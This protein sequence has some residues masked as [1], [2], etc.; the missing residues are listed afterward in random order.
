M[1]NTLTSEVRS[2]L[3][4]LEALVDK[5]LLELLINQTITKVDHI[6]TTLDQI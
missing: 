5:M 2:D 1:N 3:I 6:I 4:K